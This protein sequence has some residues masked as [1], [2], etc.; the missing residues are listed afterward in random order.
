MNKNCRSLYLDC[1]SHEGAAYAFMDKPISAWGPDEVCAWISASDASLGQYTG[2]FQSHHIDGNKLVRSSA[3]VLT[4]QLMEAKDDAFLKDIGM[5]NAYHRKI[6]RK[7]I[8]FLRQSS[9][10]VLEV[11]SPRPVQPRCR[12]MC[13]THVAGLIQGTQMSTGLF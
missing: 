2:L 13:N 10:E 12:A 4:P 6:I 3:G 7:Q 8:S 11:T 1:L 9:E 5:K